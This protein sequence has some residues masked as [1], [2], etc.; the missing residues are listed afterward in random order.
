MSGLLAAEAES[1]LNAFLA[2]FS[3]EFADFDDVNIH[4]IGVL[5]FA[6]GREGLVRLVGGFGVPLGNFVSALPLGLEGDGLLIPI[7]DGRGDSVHGHDTA[8]EGGRD[9]S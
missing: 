1:L 3:C 4:G 6:G 9:T 7:V 5:S 2:F 8:H